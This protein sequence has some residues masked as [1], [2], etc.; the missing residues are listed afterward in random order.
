MTSKAKPPTAVN[1]VPDQIGRFAR[2]FLFASVAPLLGWITDHH[3][4]GAFTAVF[5]ATF[6]VA[7]RN[8]HP[9]VPTKDLP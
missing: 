9:T 5:V 6:E 4:L 7:W 2:L 3:T 1:H 8:Y